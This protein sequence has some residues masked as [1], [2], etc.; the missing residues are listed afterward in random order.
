MADAARDLDG[1]NQ[2]SFGELFSNKFMRRHTDFDDIE[3]FFEESPWE[4]EDEEDFEEIPEDEFDEYV[5]DTTLFDTW[6]SML[7]K[8]AEKW[9]MD[10]LGF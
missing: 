7:D 10:Q 8:A 9:M 2:V 5:E 1:E 4:V 3:A 6:E